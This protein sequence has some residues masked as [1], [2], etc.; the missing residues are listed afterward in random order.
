MVQTV[1]R[2]NIVNDA[3]LKLEADS[4]DASLRML[5]FA[6]YVLCLLSS[7]F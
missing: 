5:N 4:G 7:V 1:N 6:K 2:L 3:L